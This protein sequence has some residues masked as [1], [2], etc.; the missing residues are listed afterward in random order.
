MISIDY[1][2]A[3]L[4]NLKKTGLYNGKHSSAAAEKISG[5]I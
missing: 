1:L 5:K 3:E 4:L 2:N